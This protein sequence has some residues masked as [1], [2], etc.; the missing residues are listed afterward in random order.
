MWLKKLIILLLL[1]HSSLFGLEYHTDGKPIYEPIDVTVTPMDG[2]IVYPMTTVSD[3]GTMNSNKNSISL[4]QGWNL[5]GVDSN[6]TLDTL[7]DKIGMSNL[8]SIKGS[9]KSYVLDENPALNSFS[10]LEKG[11]GYWI[12]VNQ[13]VTFDYEIVTYSEKIIN[14]QMGWNL[15]SP[16]SE[17]TLNEIKSQVGDSNLE[18]IQGF[19]KT[20]KKLYIENGT[21]FLNDFTKFEPSKGYWIKVSTN[22]SLTF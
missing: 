16:L 15:I 21:S 10:R 9:S 18:V 2:L 17:L 7:I 3:T 4:N 19:D 13:D 11:K 22:S 20:Y 12:E 5:V 6:M 1:V 14:L 8:K